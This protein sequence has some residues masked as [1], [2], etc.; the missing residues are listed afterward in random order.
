MLEIIKL[1][2]SYPSG[3]STSP[4]WRPLPR[5]HLEDGRRAAAAAAA[6]AGG[7]DTEGPRQAPWPRSRCRRR[8]AERQG[9]EHL[10][11]VLNPH[12][13]SKRRAAGPRAPP[14]PRC[15][16]RRHPQRPLYE[17]I[18]MSVMKLLFHRR[19]VYRYRSAGGQR[20]NTSRR[21]FLTKAG[22]GRRPEVDVVDARPR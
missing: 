18:T 2:R 22:R 15:K 20:P 7:S 3:T 11:P 16:R 1:T 9:H 14:P 6:V 12:Q 10:C 5:G 4:I 19:R 21:S 17:V 8:A 13:K